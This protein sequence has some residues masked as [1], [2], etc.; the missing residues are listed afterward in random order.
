MILDTEPQV[1]PMT[2]ALEWAAA[3]REQGRQRY[4]GAFLLGALVEL[5]GSPGRN[6]PPAAPDPTC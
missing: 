4:D 1:V 3:H 5:L 2:L 6:Q